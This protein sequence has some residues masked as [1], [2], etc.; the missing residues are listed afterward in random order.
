[1]CN[2]DNLLLTTFIVTVISYYI[3]FILGVIFG[4]YLRKNQ[5]KEKKE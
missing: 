5:E 4:Y 1:M 2:G 3:I